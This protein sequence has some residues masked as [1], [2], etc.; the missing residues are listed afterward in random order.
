MRVMRVLTAGFKTEHADMIGEQ[1]R[2]AGHTVVSGATLQTI[3]V[4]L[5]SARPETILLSD[6][7]PKALSNWLGKMSAELPELLVCGVKEA[8]EVFAGDNALQPTPPLR[9]R[10]KRSPTASAPVVTGTTLPPKAKALH[11]TTTDGLESGADLD[12]KL[13]EV[14]FADYHRVLEIERGASTYVIRTAYERLSACYAA[15]N[16]PSALVADELLQLEEIQSGLK[17]A[18]ALLGQPKFQ[19]LYEE[20]LDVRTSTSTR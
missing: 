16:W 6:S 9:E 7:A 5:T 18:L 8:C 10:P 2:L 1:A 3:K 20:A 12:R 19:A 11:P 14:R 4:L 13:S 17:D 15:Q